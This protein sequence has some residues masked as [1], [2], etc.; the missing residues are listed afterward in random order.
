MKQDVLATL[1]QILRDL[2]ADD[3][4][5]LTMD[6]VRE[7]IAGWDSFNYINFIVAVESEYGIKFRL[8]EVESFRDV[9]AIVDAIATA[10]A[11]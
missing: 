7:D 9:G 8:A 3:D 10:R 1:T 2:L 4:I 11:R 5:E 6:T